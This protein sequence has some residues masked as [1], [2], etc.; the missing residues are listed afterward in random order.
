MNARA[1]PA[2]GVETTMRPDRRARPPRT[3][4]SL[5]GRDDELAHLTRLLRSSGAGLITISGRSGSGKT[6]LALEA[7]Q[8]VGP[9]L[10]GGAIL[11]NTNDVED[12]ALLG[13]AV[14]AALNINVAPGQ[15]PSAAI[16]RELEYQPT[17]L[18]FDDIDHLPGAG[19]WL[20]ALINDAP[21]TKVLVTAKTP[22][23]DPGEHVVRVTPLPTL[24][25]K[26]A[27][28]VELRAS[29]AVVLF[30]D[31]AAAVQHGFKLD[32]SD[33]ESGG[34]AVSPPGRA[35]AGD[36]ACRRARPDAVARRP[37]SPAGSRYSP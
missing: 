21:D 31:R 19:E 14:A 3:H 7:A 20:A 10:P 2:E 12:V 36:R 37:A 6:R 15:E 18:I 34:G 24:D 13:T 4:T 17:L 26:S 29:E 27:S 33:L 5:I 30:A 16:V 9:D 11:I 28:A 32:R 1:V 25:E 35:A 22:L 8:R 23:R